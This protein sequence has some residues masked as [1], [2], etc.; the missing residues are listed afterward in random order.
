MS[1]SEEVS[2]PKFERDF[3]QAMFNGDVNAVR[4]L[5]KE[6][7][8]LKSTQRAD[9]MVIGYAFNVPETTLSMF[10]VLVENGFEI[11]LWKKGKLSLLGKAISKKMYDVA[12]FLL[13][14]GANPNLDRELIG[15]LNVKDAEL[16]LKFVRLLLAH[17]VDVN[18]RCQLYDSDSYFTALDWTKDEKVRKLLI[19]HG[20][21]TS[22]ELD[23][24]NESPKTAA[25]LPVQ[26]EHQDLLAY[27]ETNYG[28]VEPKSIIETL[29]LGFSIEVKQIRPGGDRK[30]LTLFTAG[31]SNQPMKVSAGKEEWQ[32]AE[33]FMQLP[34]DWKIDQLED[35]Q[36]NWPVTWLQTIARYPHKNSTWL[37]G[38]FT[39]I[40]N[41][42]PPQPLAPNTSMSCLMLLA[43]KSF[44]R[45]DGKQ[46]WLY[47]ITPIYRE[48]RDME[49]KLGV[50]ALMRAFDRQSVP[51]IY[52]PDR[53]N[54]GK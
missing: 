48:E 45:K 27:F 51:F 19:A 13:Q 18:E 47:Q 43:N 23:C 36:W 21:K 38:A 8:S 40:A 29:S 15:A 7:P 52:Q 16:R 2:T 35:P 44:Q 17:N 20:A 32:Y 54:V 3:V 25:A 4:V 1:M 12:D 22:E 30:H 41:Q 14:S 24:L 11:N 49:R 6:F 37:G 31:L 50:P 28:H 5:L 42:E 34:G 33:L 9:I 26:S 46:V 10:K 39:I 53:P